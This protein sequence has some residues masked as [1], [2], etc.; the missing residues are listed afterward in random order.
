MIYVLTTN[1]PNKIDEDTFYSYLDLLPLHMQENILKYVK[2]QDRQ[3]RLFSK[4]LLLKGLTQ[5]GFP[6]DVLNTIEYTEYN[7]PYIKG[8]INFNIASSGSAVV[9]SI[10]HGL[11]LG[12]DIEQIR[13]LN[14]F[15]FKNEINPIEWHKIRS[16]A[17][18]LNAF[19][20]YWSKAEAAM[21]ADGRGLNIP[22]REVVFDK[23]NSV[24]FCNEIW[25]IRHLNLY[26]GYASH[27]AYNQKD[28]ENIF[29]KKIECEN[30]KSLFK[31]KKTSLILS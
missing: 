31:T 16:A 18:E 1:I 2:W 29:I 12:I 19:C 13:T 4:L 14:I 17:N 11:Q 27:I 5:L 28:T 8:M 9:C 10:G 21:K 22:L 24:K 6:D 25:F 20:D 15:E 7:K 30:F 26:E 3:N 23:E